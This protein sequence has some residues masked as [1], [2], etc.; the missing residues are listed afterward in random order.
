MNRTEFRYPGGAL[1]IAKIRDF[2]EKH[3]LSGPMAQTR[4]CMKKF[5]SA[6]LFLIVYWRKHL[7]MTN[8]SDKKLLSYKT[9]N[10]FQTV[11]LK[12]AVFDQ[13]LIF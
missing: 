4:A 5:L 7:S 9:S 1:K 8:L 11:K 2:R 12:F 13:N 6:K 10:A 3:H